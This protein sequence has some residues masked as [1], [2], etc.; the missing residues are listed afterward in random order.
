MGSFASLKGKDERSLFRKSIFRQVHSQAALEIGSENKE[1]QTGGI[2]ALNQPEI[3]RPFPNSSTHRAH[4]RYHHQ[5]TPRL[6]PI[7]LHPEIDQDHPVHIRIS[8]QQNLLHAPFGDT[9][10]QSFG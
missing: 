1:A 9:D 8:A 7:E 4:A 10:T 3:D 5:S 2:A 6:A